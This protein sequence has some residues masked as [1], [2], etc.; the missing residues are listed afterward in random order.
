MELKAG[1]TVVGKWSGQRIIIQHHLGSGAN[2]DVYLVRCQNRSAAMKVS[3][4]SGD[5]AL[6]WGILQKLARHGHLFPQ[7]ILADDASGADL[8]YFYLMEWVPGQSFAEVFETFTA[9]QQVTIVR[10][11]LGGFVQLHGTGHAFCDVKPDNLLVQVHPTLTV[12]FVDVGGV[13]PFGRSVRQ[14]TPLYDRAFWQLGSRQSQG[15]YDLAAVALLIL[16]SLCHQ[17]LS[18]AQ[19]MTPRHR[20]QWV[21]R[22]LANLST[23]PLQP[24]LR[25]ILFGKISDATTALAVLQQLEASMASGTKRIVSNRSG[26]TANVKSTVASAKVAK[27]R[28]DWT[29]RVMWYSLATAFSVACVAWAAVLGWI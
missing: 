19:K 11:I 13:T 6:E 10:K 22:S 7:P 12:R 28:M 25:A 4:Q 24:A 20:Q 15:S 3:L 27:N 17:S 14:F 18:N 26:A 23:H 1:S 8:F 16:C 5:I 21:Q 9:A 2:G 29:E